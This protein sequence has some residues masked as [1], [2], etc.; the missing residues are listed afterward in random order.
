[1]DA[2][3]FQFYFFNEQL[4]E[5]SIGISCKHNGLAKNYL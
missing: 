5:V 3:N 4:N 2:L 1:M